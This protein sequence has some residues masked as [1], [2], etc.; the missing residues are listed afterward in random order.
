MRNLFAL[1]CSGAACALMLYAAA[2]EAK[3]RENMKQIGPTCS[4]LGKKI[5]AKDESASADAKKLAGWF[6]EV[7]NFWKEKKAGDA[8][9]FSIT[10]SDQFKLIAR[11]TASG[12]WDAA[13]ESF[14]RATATCAGCHQAHREKAADGSWKIK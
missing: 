1:G 12:N 5:A 10:A 6:E 7:H 2:D 8:M 14:K 11:E 4:G 13:G 3:Y 9:A